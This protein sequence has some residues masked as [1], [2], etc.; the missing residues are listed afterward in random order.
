MQGDVDDTEFKVSNGSAIFYD[1]DLNKPNFIAPPSD[2][3]NLYEQRIEK[4]ENRIS[5]ICYDMSTNQSQESGIALDIKF[6][7][8]NASLTKFSRALEDFE[9]RVFDIICK[10]LTISNDIEINYPK[11]FSI[12]DIKKEIAN[13][14]EVKELIDSPTYHTQKALQIVNNDL[15]N[16]E[17]DAFDVIKGEIED[18]NKEA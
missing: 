16:L 7:G 18:A 2:P 8:L 3:A 17:V 4:I 13:L 15:T 12:I 5:E 10:Y 14:S 11:T 1:R 6:Q 9:A